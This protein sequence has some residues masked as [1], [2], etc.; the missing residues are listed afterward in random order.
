M[1]A[2]LRPLPTLRDDLREYLDWLERVWV[3]S[4]RGEPPKPKPRPPL[5]LIQGGRDGESRRRSR[6]ANVG[7][8]D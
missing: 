7:P 1:P 5:T 3:P 2:D 8:R 4:I 6:S